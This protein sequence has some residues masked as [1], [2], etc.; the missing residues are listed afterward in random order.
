[1]ST[2]QNDYNNK[3]EKN[4]LNIKSEVGAAIQYAMREKT[5]SEGQSHHE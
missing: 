2:L 3:Q 5:V 1:M 4:S